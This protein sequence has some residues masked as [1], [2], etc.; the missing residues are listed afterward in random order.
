MVRRPLTRF[1]GKWLRVFGVGS[2]TVALAG[3]CLAAAGTSADTNRTVYSFTE[4]LPVKG[5]TVLRAV[6]APNEGRL[7]PVEF[8]RE[9]R[10]WVVVAESFEAYAAAK[11][12][13]ER[14]VK[15]AEEAR[16][17]T[18]SLRALETL[19]RAS[20]GQ[21]IGFVASQLSP[22]QRVRFQAELARQAREGSPREVCP[23]S[24]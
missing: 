24:G 5:T 20:L 3:I 7:K 13:K 19:P 6:R 4:T 9:K 8:S 11:A 10:G 16:A 14:E 23:P 21:Q 1:M 22:D 17:K 12:A 18:N 15:A 2:A